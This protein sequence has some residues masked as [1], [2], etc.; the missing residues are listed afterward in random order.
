MILLIVANVDA[1]G[2]P[3]NKRENINLR[4]EDTISSIKKWII[5]KIFNK[6]IIVENS[7]NISK[8]Y[9]RLEIPNGCDV[10][11]LGYEGQDFPRHYGKGYGIYEELKYTL[12]H[13]KLIKL[14]QKLC[15]VSGRYY[16]KNADYII[17]NLKYDFSTG[18]TNNLKYSFS[19]LFIVDQ[20]ILIKY[21]F[22]KFEKIDES[23]GNSF[24]HQLAKGVLLAIS[25][26]IN[27][28]L[29][30][31]VPVID[32]Y[33]GTSNQKYY[34]NKSKTLAIRIYSRFKKFVFE[35]KT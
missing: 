16:I 17:K 5:S 31:E 33:S 13:S 10:E 26:G 20:N 27:W 15:I 29:P 24:E 23:I 19:P 21:I 25:E 28:E 7:N 30:I 22:P 34:S 8:I 14:D 2:T 4:L 35:Y 1:K 11:F 18:M 6:I 12:I 9:E 3:F 32:G